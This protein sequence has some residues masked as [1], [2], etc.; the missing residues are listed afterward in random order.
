M[1]PK[2]REK[3]FQAARLV[4]GERPLREVFTDDFA[5]DVN[6]IAVKSRL[7]LW[8]PEMPAARREAL[9]QEL[10]EP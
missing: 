7:R 4:A 3:V 2:E 5:G 10:L 6:R 8:L 1:T 9:V